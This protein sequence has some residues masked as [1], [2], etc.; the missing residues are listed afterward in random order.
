MDAG[1]VLALSWPLDV[2]VNRI[3]MTAFRADPSC[4]GRPLQ[5]RAPRASGLLAA[6]KEQLLEIEWWF[7]NAHDA[8][9]R[10]CVTSPVQPNG[11]RL[12]GPS[13]RLIIA[14]R[15]RR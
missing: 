11:G 13:A 9:V 2:I 6:G 14:V 4:V 10:M 12:R 15:G 3:E 5:D 1:D 8:I 7:V